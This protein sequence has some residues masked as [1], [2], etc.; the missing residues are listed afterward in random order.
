MNIIFFVRGMWQEAN[1]TRVRQSVKIETI[2][3]ILKV[4][5]VK[6]RRAML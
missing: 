6:D 4:K 5:E 3:W 1:Y 2:W